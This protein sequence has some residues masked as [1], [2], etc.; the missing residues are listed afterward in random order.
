MMGSARTK[1]E[2]IDQ[3][4]W[5]IDSSTLYR[6]PAPRVTHSTEQ[7]AA[8]LPEG[9]ARPE[10]GPVNQFGFVCVWSLPPPPSPSPPA[11]ANDNYSGAGTPKVLAQLSFNARHGRDQDSGS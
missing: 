6:G 10:R 5:R 8:D 2:F 3:A 1:K 4:N 11:L 7:F 9:A